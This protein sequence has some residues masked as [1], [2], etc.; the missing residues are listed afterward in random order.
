MTI[1]RWRVIPD[2]DEAPT[3][4]SQELIKEVI[5][6]FF[7]FIVDGDFNIVLNF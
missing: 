3:I 5:F 4:V 7:I 2:N 6:S 1:Y